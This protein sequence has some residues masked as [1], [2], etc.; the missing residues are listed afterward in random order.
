M[1]TQK[2]FTACL[3]FAIGVM[4]ISSFV[5]GQE[6]PEFSPFEASVSVTNADPVIVF[7]S[8]VDEWPGDATPG[9]VDGVAGGTVDAQ[10]SFIARDDNGEGDLN[11]STAVAQF[12]GPLG[13][14]R[15]VGGPQACDEVACNGWAGGTCADANVRNFSCSSESSIMMWYY[16]EPAL[17]PVFWDTLVRIDDS[18]PGSPAECGV[19]SSVACAQ[20]EYGEIDAIWNDPVTT[21]TWASVDV[22]PTGANQL[23]TAPNDLVSVYN[24]GNV[25]R[26]DIALEGYNL[27]DSGGSCTIFI[28]SNAFSASGSNGAGPPPQQCNVPTSATQLPTHGGTTGAISGFSIPYG[29]GTSDDMYFCIP[30]PLDGYGLNPALTYA[31]SNPGTS[32]WNTVIL[33]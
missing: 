33:P 17:N 1:L 29:L 31:T 6:D 22:S 15:P 14:L 3:L 7:V 8:D 13:T 16:D 9:R 18:V 32:P 27:C 4:L 11:P 21:I 28:P 20:F 10:I 24:Y 2:V 26:N 12:I 30:G 23:P 5:I 25:L 19:G